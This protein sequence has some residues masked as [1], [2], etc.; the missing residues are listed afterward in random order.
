MRLY[1]SHYSRR[2]LN[3]YLS[4]GLNWDESFQSLENTMLKGARSTVA[5]QSGL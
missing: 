4:Q 2:R 5:F 1:L 3:Q